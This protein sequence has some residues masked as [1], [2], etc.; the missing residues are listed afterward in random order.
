MIVFPMRHFRCL[1]TSAAAA[2]LS[3]ASATAQPATPAQPGTAAPLTLQECIRLA[4]SVQSTAG[5][6]R[7][8]VDIANLGIRQARAGFLPQLQW[9]NGFTYN[10]PASNLIA[11]QSFIALNSV[12]EYSSLF[13]ASL[14]LDTSGRLRAAYA[15]ARADQDAARASLGLAQRDLK[16]AVTAAFYRLALTRR[17]VEVAQSSLDEARSFEKRT[18]LLFQGGEAAQAD[19]VKASAESA[20]LEQALNAAQLDAASANHDLASFWTA[21]VEPALSIV[22]PL[23]QPVPSPEKPAIDEPFLKR[24]EF[25]LYDAQHRGFLADYRRARGD[26]LPQ[27][28][29]GFQYG[30]DS[31]RLNWADRGSA[32]IVGLTIPIFDWFRAISTARQS[33]IQ[34][35][36]V[37]TST[38]IARRQFSR[39]YQTALDQ[40]KMI[41]Q[42]IAMTQ[43]QVKFSEDNLRLSRVRYEGG[44]GLAL[45][46]VAA[47]TQLAQAR[48]NYY[49]SIANYLNAR[50]DLEVAAGR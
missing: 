43:T 48:A 4:E 36:I 7:Q 2:V 15:R 35:Q 3:I 31:D 1:A 33:R 16:R 23:R 50:A 28:T 29:I 34:A 13:T 14:E 45:D 9:S 47:Q 6:A 42:Q 21:D 32:T 40:V 27:T 25:N 11:P 46:V 12:R 37:E 44:E 17:L 41:Y 30:I 26:L 18:K 22:D 38:A 10:S 19:V 39:D 24:L 20:F 5:M 49:T 8:Q